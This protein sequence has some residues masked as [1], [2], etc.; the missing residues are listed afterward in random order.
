MTEQHPLQ[1]QTDSAAVF[2]S[3]LRR[4]HACHGFAPEARIAPETLR[5]I[6]EAGRLSPSSFGL[7]H[8]RFVVL[9]STEDKAAA[10]AACF[11]QPQVGSASVVIVILARLAELQP[12]HPYAQRLLAREYP[13]EAFAPA[14]ANYRAFCAATDLRAWSLSQCH[15]AAA[16]LMNAAASHGLDSCAIGGFIPEHMAALLKLDRAE[17]DIALVLSL[18][19]CA[20]PPGERMRLPLDEM[21]E[22]R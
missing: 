4:R 2:M 6:L 11:G 3:I 13:G 7:E 8:W 17:A 16:N 22:Y 21:V 5:D 18:G 10:Q 9:S 19:V 15:I 20:T 12:D 1:Q 14:L